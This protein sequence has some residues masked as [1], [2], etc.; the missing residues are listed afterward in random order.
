MMLVLVG[1]ARNTKS[2]TGGGRAAPF[3]LGD[4]GEGQRAPSSVSASLY[5]FAVDCPAEGPL[6]R[7]PVIMMTGAAQRPPHGG[8]AGG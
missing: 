7:S 2:A 8:G 6:S 3:F 4:R 1:R 5:G